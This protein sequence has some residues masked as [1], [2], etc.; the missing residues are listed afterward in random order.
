MSTTPLI[1]LSDYHAAQAISPSKLK[2]WSQNRKTPQRYHAKYI[3]RTVKPEPKSEAFVIGQMVEDVVQRG[4]IGSEF[5]AKAY[6]SFRSNE[7][8]AW[9]EM[10]TAQGKM[11]YDAEQ[12]AQALVVA[13]TALLHPL[14]DAISKHG[15]Q[16]RTFRVTLAGGV[17]LQCRPDWFL[18]QGLDGMSEPL[19]VDLKTCEDLN[20]FDG[21]VFKWGYHW[22]AHLTRFMVG[23]ELKAEY[24]EA[25]VVNYA[26]LVV[27]KQTPPSCQLIY[28]T[29]AHF[30]VALDDLENPETGILWD[31]L[32][33]YRSNDWTA[34]A[35]RNAEAPRWAQR[36][37]D[38]AA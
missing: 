5:V 2:F 18:P 38:E 12:Y 22:A 30:A 24:G 37:T 32:R 19:A 36:K 33:R 9:R 7:A 14:A 8:K 10:Q 23:Q 3:A 13:G 28:P 31:L 21:D 26:W 27:D 34:P 11:V 4:E 29:A 20:D 25:P 16:Q 17:Q 15:E 1:S 35:T 6:D